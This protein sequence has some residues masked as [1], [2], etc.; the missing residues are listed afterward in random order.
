MKIGDCEFASRRRRR[1]KRRIYQTE[2][3]YRAC[4]ECG[5]EVPLIGDWTAGRARKVCGET[6]ARA[7]KTRL[8]RERRKGGR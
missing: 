1:G 8:Q 4:P 2:I 7:R 5:A 3:V 6:C